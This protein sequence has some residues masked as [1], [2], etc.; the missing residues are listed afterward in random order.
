MSTTPYT[1]Y[2]RSSTSDC[3][4]VASESSFSS[5]TETNR[6]GTSQGSPQRRANQNTKSEA[7]PI[8]ELSCGTRSTTE[9]PTINTKKEH[10][11]S[12]RQFVAPFTKANHFF[13]CPWL[14][15]ECLEGNSR[16]D[17]DASKSGRGGR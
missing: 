6:T 15:P 16:V 3:D 8:G 14:D 2:E 10:L 4:T 7:R 9:H 11:L 1:Y 17:L 13:L 12:A 5:T